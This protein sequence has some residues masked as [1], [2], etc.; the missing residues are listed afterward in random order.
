MA[1]NL[2]WLEIFREVARQGSLTGA[3]ETL[4]YTQPTLSR[5][6]SALEKELAVRLFDRLPRGVRLTEAG[7]LFLAHSEGVLDRVEVARQSLD[8]LRTLATGRLRLGAFETAGTTLVPRA[9]AAF[10]AD[11]P[12]VELSLVEGNS[13]TQIE[14]LQTGEIDL[15]VLSAYPHQ[16]LDA[17]RL[18]LHHLMDDALLIALPTTHRF[19]S[20]RRLRFAELADETWIEGFPDAL[21]TLHEAGVRAGIPARAGFAVREWSAKLGFVAA[22]LGITFVPLLAAGATRPGVRLVPLQTGDAPVRAV[23]AAT[24]RGLTRPPAVVAFLPYLERTAKGLHRE[25]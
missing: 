4:G 6:L 11:H 1:M 25:R 22:G 24:W 15:A 10:R 3:A 19:A 20:R 16:P 8:A 14:W 2:E 9:L 5:Q 18:E 21:V 17:G 7:R 23:H 12:Q 13:S